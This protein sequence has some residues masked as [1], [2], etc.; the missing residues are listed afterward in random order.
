M[1][2][3]SG[4]YNYEHFSFSLED[5]AF[6]R[7]QAEA[8]ALGVTAPDFELRDVEGRPHRLDTMRGRPVVLE[9]GSY[10]CPIFCAQIPAMEG[11]ARRHANA[12]F[13]VIYTREAHPGE[14]TPAHRSNVEKIAAASLLAREEQLHRTVLVDDVEGSVHAAYGRVWDAVFVLDAEG[15]VVLRRAWNDPEQVDAV[16]SAFERNEAP[17]A[18]DSVDMARVTGRGG[19]GHGLLRGG[20]Q[21]LLDFY[22]SAPPPVRERLETSESEDVRSILAGA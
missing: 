22:R 1:A 17:G 21:A 11:L 10:T 3:D 18:F 9:F 4:V 8:P 7:W 20:T 6:A 13:M 14:V 15:R 5:G 12:S 19:F 16:L 2:G